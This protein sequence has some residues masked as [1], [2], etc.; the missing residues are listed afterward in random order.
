M[1]TEKHAFHD[2]IVKLLELRRKYDEAPTWALVI[3]LGEEV[4]E[5]NEIM[6]HELGFLRHKN[7]EW[8][9]TPVEEMAD[10][11]NVLLGILIGH[12]PDKTEEEIAHDLLEALKKKGNKYARVLGAEELFT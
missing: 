3:K 11:M 12:Y 9:D 8:K 7:K 1:M 2:A 4:G 10:I 6:L 5:L